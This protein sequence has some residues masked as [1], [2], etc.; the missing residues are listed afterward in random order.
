MPEPR[1]SRPGQIPA[2]V[3]KWLTKWRG[4]KH[5]HGRCFEACAEG[6]KLFPAL[7]AV[8]GATSRRPS[9]SAADFVGAVHCWLVTEDGVVVDPTA[10]QYDVP[11]GELEYWPYRM[12]P[13]NPADPHLNTTA[14]P[15]VQQG[16]GAAAREA[17]LAKLDPWC[18][19]VT[20]WPSTQQPERPPKEQAMSTVPPAP[21]PAPPPSSVLAAMLAINEALIQERTPGGYGRRRVPNAGTVNGI[22]GR[23]LTEFIELGAHFDLGDLEAIERAC[24]AS[25]TQGSF[26]ALD[27]NRYA[28]A[29]A[30]GNSSAANAWEAAH[31]C[32]PWGWSG[33]HLQAEIKDSPEDPERPWRATER[34][35]ASLNRIGPCS[36]IFLDGVWWRVYSFSP[37]EL[38]LAAYP[39][40]DGI[41]SEATSERKGVKRITLTRDGFAEVAKR[42]GALVKQAAVDRLTLK[43]PVEG[44]LYS[45]W[46]GKK[47]P[48]TLEA[49]LVVLPSVLKKIEEDERF[50]AGR[51]YGVEQPPTPR[52]FLEMST[53]ERDAWYAECRAETAKRVAAT[54]IDVSLSSGHNAPSFRATIGA[55]RAALPKTE[56]PRG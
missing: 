9:A 51:T 42:E 5:V 26:S 52:P 7:Y 18:R 32:K 35:P 1:P 40:D 4:R 3:R 6:V 8:V 53:E 14:H 38:R 10:H 34:R 12:Q 22:L 47:E 55:W 50:I 48:K 56:V 33:R 16:W 54:E 39:G 49:G 2:E 27:T 37:T 44:H 43:V 15:P 45:Y 21:E 25:S 28:Q 17:W 11:K 23:M 41:S 13:S 19:I 46:N 31:R 20:F 30:A 29:L 24:G 36:A